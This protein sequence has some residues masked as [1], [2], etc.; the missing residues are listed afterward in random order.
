[1]LQ[2]TTIDERGDYRRAKMSVI[3][4]NDHC[5]SITRNRLYTSKLHSD[6]HL[7]KHLRP[8]HFNSPDQRKSRVKNEYINYSLFII[9]LMKNRIQDAAIAR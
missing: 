1:M 4:L 8:E 7:L 6:G 9:H 3:G 5:L 2:M